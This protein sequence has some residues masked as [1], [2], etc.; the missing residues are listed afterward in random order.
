M[1]TAAR[2]QQSNDRRNLQ[3]RLR[4]C[5]GLAL[6]GVTVGQLTACKTSSAKDWDESGRLAYRRSMSMGRELVSNNDRTHN[7]RFE[8]SIVGFP[9]LYSYSFVG[10]S[11]AAGVAALAA[12]CVE[13][14]ESKC[15]PTISLCCQ[16]LGTF[17]SANLR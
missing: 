10:S 14:G 2:L 11:E 15:R 17:P 7:D 6:N 9:E 1:R 12:L 4:N 3:S 8:F 13:C 16:F 5:S